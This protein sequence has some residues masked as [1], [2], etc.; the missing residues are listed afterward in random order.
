LKTNHRKYPFALKEASK[1]LGVDV[2]EDCI[3]V[4]SIKAR[5]REIQ[6]ER[7]AR[8]DE[9]WVAAWDAA[10]DQAIEIEGEL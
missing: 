4:K 5:A 8:M 2:G 9:H 3:G 7:F 6:E 10:V 1:M